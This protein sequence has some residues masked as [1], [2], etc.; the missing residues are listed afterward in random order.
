MSGKLKPHTSEGLFSIAHSA[1][2]VNGRMGERANQRLAEIMPILV[3]HLHA[4][5]KEA[6]LSTE[7]WMAGIQFLTA[8]GH[9]CS[10]WRQEFILLSDVLGISMLVDAIAHARPAAATENTVLGPFHVAN[11]PLY[12]N[13]T[14]ICLDGKGERS[15]VRG[16]VLDIAGIPIS[17]ARVDVWQ[18][19]EDGFYDVQQKCLQPEWN[20]RGRFETDSQ[21]RFWFKSIKPRHY[22][23]PDDG[24]VGKLLAGL[25][26]HPNRAAHIHFIVAATGFDTAITHVFP[27]DCPYVAEDAVFG[28]KES[29]IADFEKITD[30]DQIAAAGFEAPFWLV[31]QD[32]VLARTGE[33]TLENAE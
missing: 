21:G 13:G 29:L 1:E 14:D 8:T 27:P 24:P 20:L 4:A 2:V 18:C 22:A 10:E 33:L 7:E 25:D 30:R 32:F 9:M 12:E 15:L 6:N 16:R 3:R 31:S 23:I 26:R 28:V 17:R 5:V 11:A 19:N